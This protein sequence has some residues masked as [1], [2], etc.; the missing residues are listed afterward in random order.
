[1]VNCN[2]CDDTKEETV[3]RRHQTPYHRTF[4]CSIQHDFNKWVT[5]KAIKN[6]KDRHEIPSEAYAKRGHR[7][8]DCALN[9]VL[10]LDLI[11]QHKVPAALCSCNDATKCYDHILHAITNIC[12]QRVGVCPKTCF[13]M[14]GTLQQMKHHIKTAYGIS[15]NSYGC[16]QT[17]L[18]G[19]LQGNGAGPA[20]WMLISM[21]PL[22]NMLHTQGFGFKSTNILSGEE[23]QFT[24]Y[25]YVVDNTDLIHTGD[26]NTTPQTVFDEMQNMLNHWEEGGLQATGGALVPKNIYWYGIHFHWDPVNYTWHYKTMAKLPRQLRLK[27]HRQEWETLKC[28]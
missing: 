4:S 26:A 25:T 3:T 15:H 5:K 20:I 28:L 24:C 19:V 22:I 6:S 11:R 23:Y 8:I 10:Y 9:K 12:L 16:V 7:A 14:L 1:M 17:P 18:Q 27:N 21:I 13:I 2:I